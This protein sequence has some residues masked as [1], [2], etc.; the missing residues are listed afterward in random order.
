MLGRNASRKTFVAHGRVDEW[1]NPR[2][3]GRQTEG[4]GRA[5]LLIRIGLRRMSFAFAGGGIR[6]HFGAAIGF[7]D[8]RRHWLARNR[9]EP[10][11]SGEKQA[12]EQSRGRLH[13]GPCYGAPPHCSSRLRTWIEGFEAGPRGIGLEAARDDS[14]SLDPSAAICDSWRRDYGRI[15]DRARAT[16]G[17]QLLFTIFR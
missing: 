7:L 6:L 14:G 4:A 5:T 15:V 8:D 17:S 16:A 11:R 2:D 1:S 9:R 13:D 10:K 3:Y 12:E